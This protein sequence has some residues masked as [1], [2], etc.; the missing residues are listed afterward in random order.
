MTLPPK[1]LTVAW[2]DFSQLQHNASNNNTP[3]TKRK[4][5]SRARARADRG[6][7]LSETCKRGK[8]LA[9]R[10][11]I[12][13]HPAGLTSMASVDGSPPVISQGGNR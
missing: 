8:C 6:I 13:H 12:E 4:V 2:G 10:L 5:V 11:R 3:G 1:T 9:V 7:E